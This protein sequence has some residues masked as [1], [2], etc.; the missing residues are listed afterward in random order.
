M[1]HHNRGQGAGASRLS[2]A[3]PAEWGRVLISAEVKSRNVDRE[4][5]RG[6]DV[7]TV[8]SVI[9]GE[10][11]EQSLRVRRRIWADDPDDLDS[12]LHV[13]TETTDVA[14]EFAEDGRD[15]R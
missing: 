2:G 7:V 12:P 1:H 11:P 15:G 14:D 5:A 10:V 6:S 3:G 4:H 9:G 8:L 13:L